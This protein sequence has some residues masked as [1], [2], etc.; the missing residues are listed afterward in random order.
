MNKSIIQLSIAIFIWVLMPSCTKEAE[1]E[2]RD[3]VT[4]DLVWSKEDKNAFYAK[5]YLANI[6]LP[7]GFTRVNGDYLD[8]GAGDAIPSRNLTNTNV[9]FY[10]NGLA[11]TV[12]NPDGYW[13]NS[14]QGIR[15]ANIFLSNIDSVPTLAANI[16]LWK[17]EARFIRAFMYFELLKRYGG[18]PLVGNQVFDLKSNLEIPRNTFDEVV[19][20][21]AAECDV[22]KPDLYVDGSVV[23]VTNDVGRIT[24]GAAVAL[25]TRLF[26]YAASPLWNGGAPS[27]D[28]KNK[29]LLGYTSADPLRW[30]KVIDAVTEFKAL[31]YYG[32]LQANF[33][34]LF[35]NTNTD[36]EII[37]AKQAAKGFQL[38]L[39]NGPVG[40]VNG[41]TQNGGR[42]SP[43]QNFVDAFTMNNGLPITDP[44][45][46]YNP[47]AP[48]TNR[49]SRLTG[50]VFYNG[51]PWFNRSV[52]TFEG[53][54]DK[55]NTPATV[56]VQTKT[57]YYLRKF[58]GNFATSTA[59]GA[60]FHNF[61]YF[62]YAEILLTNAEALNEVGR[63]EDAVLEIKKIRAR[64]GIAAGAN[65][66][67]GIAVGI[68]QTDM[69]TLIQNERR[70]ELAFEEHR[71]WDIRRWKIANVAV[72]GPITGM[73]ITKTG[74]TTFTYAPVT[75]GNMIF[76]DKLYFMPVPYDEVVKNSKMVQ[77]PGW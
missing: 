42:T 77:N 33:V 51:L 6:Y 29:G 27:S 48:Y 63:V 10:T 32:T 46:G 68:S 66:R 3:L 23:V 71:F 2:P 22:A 21:I 7:N 55:P 12:N 65:T 19:N 52:E 47:A 49:D 17:A 38:E 5:Q 50:T 39:D 20:Y 57:G 62:R 30:Q 25:K 26:L 4:S 56:A 41:T 70:V 74:P 54:R 44:A 75:V 45:S 34:N 72:N 28:Q 16:T 37:L 40:Y 8:A 69:R 36:P 11:S 53:G 15:N 13:N 67:Y 31:G 1:L 60:V 59:Y 43:T 58:L 9:G 73:Q 64:A 35:V 76:S 18:V 14:Y 24:R 61:I